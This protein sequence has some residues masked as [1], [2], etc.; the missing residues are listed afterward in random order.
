MLEVPAVHVVE[1]A[2]ILVVACDESHRCN[3]LH[4]RAQQ[5]D[6]ADPNLAREAS[7]ETA[8]ELVIAAIGRPR[9]GVSRTHQRD[10]VPEKDLGIRTRRRTSR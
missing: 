5:D 8:F 7:N 6:I 2:Y 3:R 4:P 1:R 9:P 10:T